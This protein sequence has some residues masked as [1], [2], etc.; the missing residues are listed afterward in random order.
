MFK[1]LIFFIYFIL[2][3]YIVLN[4]GRKRECKWCQ[5][6]QIMSESRYKVIFISTAKLTIKIDA[7]TSKQQF[8]RVIEG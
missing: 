6:R 8:L 1:Y 7:G 3:S 5:Y 4:K 2:I